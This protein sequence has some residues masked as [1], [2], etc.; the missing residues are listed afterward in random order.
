MRTWSSKSDIS[1]PS[2][3]FPRCIGLWG[4]SD[5]REARRWVRGSVGVAIS[6]KADREEEAL[7]EIPCP[8]PMPKG[9]A[10]ILPEQTLEEASPGPEEWWVSLYP[11]HTHR[12]F[13]FL[14]FIYSF[15]LFYYVQL[16]TV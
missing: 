11:T 14:I 5:I 9:I 8:P 1:S 6:G 3:S 2:R 16:A 15:Y 4:S 7:R 12:D 10:F 13:Y